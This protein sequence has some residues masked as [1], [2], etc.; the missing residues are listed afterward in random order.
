MGLNETF[1]LE[2]HEMWELDGELGYHCGNGGNSGNLGHGICP[3]LLGYTGK[4]EIEWDIH[5]E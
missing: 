2:I 4:T 3:C 1:H 5:C